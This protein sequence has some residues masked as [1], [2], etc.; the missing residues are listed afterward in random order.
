MARAPAVLRTS[1]EVFSFLFLRLGQGTKDERILIDS[2]FIFSCDR[3]YN[4]DGDVKETGA[5]SHHGNPACDVLNNF[6]CSTLYWALWTLNKKRDRE[7]K[8]AESSFL[9][10]MKLY[11][12]FMWMSNVFGMSTYSEANNSTKNII[13]FSWTRVGAFDFRSTFFLFQPFNYCVAVNGAEPLWVAV[14]N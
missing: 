2:P 9:F 5:D 13:L 1:S 4:Y 14:W 3:N 10:E 6:T 11:F 12:F 8:S 7:K